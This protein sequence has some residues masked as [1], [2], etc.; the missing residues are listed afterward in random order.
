MHK[1][2]FDHTECK[3]NMADHS[4]GAQDESN[5]SEASQAFMFC[6]ENA[7]CFVVDLIPLFRSQYTFLCS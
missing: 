3:L 7:F 5:E 2:K 6:F 1:S 4:V